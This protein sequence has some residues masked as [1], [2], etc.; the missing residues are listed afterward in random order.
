MVHFRCIKSLLFEWETESMEN[1]MSE[2]GIKCFQYWWS[3]V[4]Y[5]SDGLIKIDQMA[6]SPYFHHFIWTVIIT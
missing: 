5:V 1:R 4:V 3:Y 2:N 6:I